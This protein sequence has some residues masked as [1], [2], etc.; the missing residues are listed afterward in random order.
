M[1][2][3][4][5]TCEFARCQRG[6]MTIDWVAL[7]ASVVNSATRMPSLMVH[8]MHHHGETDLIECAAD[9]ISYA[10]SKCKR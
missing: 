3:R 5:A 7:S 8:S 10:T 2:L 4:A 9:L 1:G 6:A